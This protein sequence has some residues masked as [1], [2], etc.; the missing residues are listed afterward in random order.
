[1]LD[2]GTVIVNPR[3]DV[4]SEGPR[5]ECG[6]RLRANPGGP[7]RG[8]HVKIGGMVVQENVH[9][10]GIGRGEGWELLWGGEHVSR[11]WSHR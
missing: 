10:R 9:G 3:G 8:E 5:Q 1:M 4:G 11:G 2:L 7:K 6:E